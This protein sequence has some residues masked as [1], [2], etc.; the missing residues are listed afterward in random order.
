MAK[1]LLI[2]T[3][4]PQ[5][6][7]G[8]RIEASH[9]RTWQFV[10]PLVD[11]GHE[12][13]VCAGEVGDGR[14][15]DTGSSI[16]FPGLALFQPIAFGSRGWIAT[17]QD[18]HDRVQPDSIVAV[19][20]FPCLYATKLRTDRPIWMDIYGDQITIQQSFCH[21]ARSDRGMPTTVRFMKQ[22]LHAGDVFSVCGEHQKH[23]LTGELAMAGR[24]N[25]RSFGYE[26]ARVVLPGAPPV[27]ARIDGQAVRAAT[28]DWL[29]LK[30]DDF[31]VLW[32]GGYNTWTDVDTLFG[33]IEGAMARNVRIH[34]VSV[35]ASTYEAPDNAYQRLLRMIE[36]S[37]YAARWH[38]LG[39]QPW[40]EIPRYYQSCEIGLNIDAMHYETL[41][42]TRTRLVE[43][44]AEGLPVLTTEGT[45]LSG[46]LRDWGAGVT[47]P[48]GR[49]IRLQECLLELARDANHVVQM[50]R[51]AK[52]AARVELS[53]ERTTAPLCA[54]VQNPNPAPDR[55]RRSGSVPLAAG[56]RLRALA[57]HVAWQMT[58]RDR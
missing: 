19:N 55:E 37:P 29:G 40:S 3:P 26:F 1:V 13:A 22:V 38:M 47:F 18:V 48:V 27:Q 20:F 15:T 11:A 8:R 6:R 31:A 14:P 23:M 52:R 36:R 53:F 33:G 45:E 46:L 32:C 28:R 16:P 12:V 21:R 2:G 35:G 57:R 43:M 25:S 39:W 54:W 56:H 7:K 34:Y 41:Y 49:S 42:G 24:L 10:Q 17:L 9:Y 58:G 4:P 5:L 30:P 51:T 50:S 44:I